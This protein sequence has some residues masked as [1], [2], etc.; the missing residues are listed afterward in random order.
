VARSKTFEVSAIAV[1]LLGGVKIEHN[2]INLPDTLRGEETQSFGWM[3]LTGLSDGLLC[4]PG[5]HTKWVLIKDGKIW[6]LN[7]GLSGE[8][9][10]IVSRHS[11]LTRGAEMFD[12][13]NDA[14]AMYGV[15][16][17]RHDDQACT[18]KGL[19]LIAA[20]QR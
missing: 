18:L 2:I 19:A 12:A 16:T 7:T 1:T 14:F 4:L 6:Q 10:E 5:T 11:M 15:E 9:F 20:R 17:T 8:L 3:A 13:P